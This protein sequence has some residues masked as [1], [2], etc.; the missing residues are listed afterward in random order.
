M[1]IPK[2][3]YIRGVKHRAWISTLPCIISNASDVQC[4]HIRSGNKAG[5]G[6]KPSDKY[7]VP[8]SVDQHRVQHDMSEIE[9]WRPYLGIKRASKLAEELYFNSGNTNKAIILIMEWRNEIRS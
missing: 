1:L 3:K 7:C 4:A 8:L 5:M 6:K 9:F 2:T